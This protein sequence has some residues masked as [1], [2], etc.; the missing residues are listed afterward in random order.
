MPMSAWSVAGR[1]SGTEW[2]GKGKVL[3][4]RLGETEV[5]C[6]HCNDQS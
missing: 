5:P 1:F 3:L 6:R 4:T 2:A